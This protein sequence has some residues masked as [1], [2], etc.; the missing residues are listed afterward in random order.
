MLQ[1]TKKRKK[2]ECNTGYLKVCIR[3]RQ[4]KNGCNNWLKYD[5]KLLGVQVQKFGFYN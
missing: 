1:K 5:A 2:N 4:K 3:K